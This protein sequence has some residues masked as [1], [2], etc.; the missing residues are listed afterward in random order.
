MDGV[1]SGGGDGDFGG[2]GGGF[3]GVLLGLGGGRE[4]KDGV[5]DFGRGG[6]GNSGAG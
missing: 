4:E 2:V 6:I 3:G 1:L 5:L